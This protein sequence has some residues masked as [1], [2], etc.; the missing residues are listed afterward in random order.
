MDFLVDWAEFHGIKE[1]LQI[2]KIGDFIHF[3][4]NEKE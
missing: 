4:N 1:A 3:L 2:L